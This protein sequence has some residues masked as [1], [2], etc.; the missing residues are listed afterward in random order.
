[1]QRTYADLTRSREELGYQPKVSLAEGL[2]EF[3]NW[4]GEN[5][6]AYPW[7]AG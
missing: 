5:E 3:V 2:R 6:Q 7:A 1:V 4:L